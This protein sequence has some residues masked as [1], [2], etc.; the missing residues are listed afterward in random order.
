M[1]EEEQNRAIAVVCVWTKANRL[2]LN[3]VQ[4]LNAMHQAEQTLTPEQFITYVDN[5]LC[6]LCRETDK[7]RWSPDTGWTP[8]MVHATAAQKAEAF[9]RTLNL[10]VD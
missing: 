5:H 10:W 9:L 8:A 6:D 7:N 3:Y 2:P 1:T 4:D